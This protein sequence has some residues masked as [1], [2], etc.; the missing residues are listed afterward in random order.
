MTHIADLY[1]SRILFFEIGSNILVYNYKLKI[2]TIFDPISKNLI[3]KAHKS[4]TSKK[5][6]CKNTQYNWRNM[7]RKIVFSHWYNTESF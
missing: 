1:V 5:A 2:K 4:A 6:V 3:L 7:C